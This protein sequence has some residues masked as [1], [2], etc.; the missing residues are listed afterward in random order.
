MDIYP[1]DMKML[2]QRNICMLIFIAALFTIAKI[3][4]SG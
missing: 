2:Y 4:N 1:K 3:F